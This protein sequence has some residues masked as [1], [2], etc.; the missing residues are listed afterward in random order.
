[1]KFIYPAII[2]PRAEGG[3]HAVF[4]DLACCEADG[5]DLHDV[6]ERANDAARD[7]IELEL[8]EEAPELPPITDKHDLKLGKGELIRDICVNVRMFE[9]WDE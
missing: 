1:M 5:E 4:P 7:W 3:F 9:G 6:I 8:S 2:S